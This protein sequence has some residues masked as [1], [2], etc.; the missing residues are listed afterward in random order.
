VS[1]S[2]RAHQLTVSQGA[3]VVLDRIDLG[4]AAGD[5]VGVVGPNGV[6]KTTLLRAL[7]GEITPEHG[8]VTLHPTTATIVRVP[9]E[10]AA[11]PG[12]TLADYLARCTGVAA[13]DRRLTAATEAL[14]AQRPGSDTEYADALEAWLALGGADLPERAAAVSEQLGLAAG[15]VDRGAGQLSGGQSARLRLATALLVR[16]DVLLLDEPTNDLDDS[17]LQALESMVAG[18]GGGIVLVSHDREFCARTVERVLEI[19]EFTHQ[20]R[21]Y[22]GGWQAYLD[23]RAA[24]RARAEEEYETYASTRDDL[25]A[26]A[27]RQREW[28]RTGAKTA[29]NP[30][31]EPD[32]HI[33]F[34]EVQRAQRTGAKAA[35]SERALD[36]LEVVEEPRDPWELRLTI[37]SAGRGSEVAFA[38]REAVIERGDVRLGPVDLVI[39]AG[40][41]LRITGPNGSGKSTLVEALL[42]RLPLVSGTS[43]VGPGV[44]IGEMDQTRLSLRGPDPLLDVFRGLT[45]LS[46]VDARTLLAKFRLGAEAVLRPVDSLSPGERTRAGLAVFQ[47]RGSTCVVLDEPTNH[48]DLPA[49]EQLESALEPYDGTV[50]LITHDRQLAEHVPVDRELDVRTLSPHSA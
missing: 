16:A 5:R 42:G 12:E 40:E 2:L 14:G 15:L 10:S 32:K 21:E 47:A 46:P 50:L 26:R 45:A 29:A 19:D 18:F 37:T 17:G 22:A 35:M 11:K 27:R 1:A 44:V 3:V 4:V 8:R 38:L 34:R 41:R 43:Y 31:R 25:V 7:S 20:A 30:R 28:A 49:I 36:R 24:A 9:Q 39:G 23:E 13:A 48:L 33:R 6:G